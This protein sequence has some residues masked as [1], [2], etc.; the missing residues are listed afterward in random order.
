MDL[1]AAEDDILGPQAA[2]R[3]ACNLLE[4]GRDAIGR[5]AWEDTWARRG[6]RVAPLDRALPETLS[7]RGPL[8]CDAASAADGVPWA[9]T[10]L[11]DHAW[12]WIQWM[13][14]RPSVEALNQHSNWLLDEP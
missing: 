8:S 3:R 14:S 2:D 9:N 5:E 11:V 13:V 10:A 1:R 4:V 12:A 6:E 7:R